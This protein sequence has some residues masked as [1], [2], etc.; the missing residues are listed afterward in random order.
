MIYKLY[1]T[2][3]NSNKP[4]RNR[5]DIHAYPVWQINQLWEAV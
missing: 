3:Y 4:V 5:D 2:D 1:Y